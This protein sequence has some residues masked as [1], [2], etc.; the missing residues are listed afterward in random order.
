MDNA[1][2][3]RVIGQQGF[4]TTRIP[5]GERPGEVQIS[6][7]GGNES[8]IAYATERVDRGERILVIGRRPGRA[9]DV[10]IFAV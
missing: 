10:T 4:V 7:R 2:E 8:F 1:D 9:V 3:G 6:L 5:G